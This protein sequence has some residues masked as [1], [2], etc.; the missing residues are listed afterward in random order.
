MGPVIGDPFPTPPLHTAGRRRRRRSPAQEKWTGLLSPEVR[1]QTVV[2]FIL[3]D[4][5]HPELVTFLLCAVPCADHR[6][7]E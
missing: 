2:S 1:A 5:T 4:L 7:K 6:M 3:S